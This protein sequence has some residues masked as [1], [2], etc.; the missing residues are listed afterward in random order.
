M[1]VKAPTP[2]AG[3]QTPA[4]EETSSPIDDQAIRQ[5]LQQALAENRFRLVYQ[6]I[7]PLHA[8][9]AE[10]YEV[11]IRMIDENGAEVPPASFMPV[12]EK[13]GLMSQIDRW[14]I[15]AAMMTL[16]KQHEA[17]KETSLLV[18]LSSES[19]AD[20]YLVAWIG[21]RLTG[22]H[23]PGDTLIFEIKESC[24][25][26]NPE[27]A[28]QLINGLKQLH[29]RTALGHF[30]S[31]PRS[32]DYLEQL[33]VDFIKLAG[34][35]VDNLS[36]DT[37]SQAMVKAVVQTAHD[38]GTLTVATFVQDASKMATLWQC[39]VDYIQGYFLQ[40]PDED[41]AYDFSEQDE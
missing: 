18:K 11:L 16:A 22:L 4:N 2:P 7:V 29:C 28:K 20:Q 14:V 35:F 1:Q 40:A 21:E 23:L 3:H 6:P 13:A 33:H 27:A 5:R 8:Q 17:G 31:D 30:G 37:K 9:P 36:G 41:M 25:M 38:L 12:A 39:N 24:V 15:G 26:R 34:T 19:V 32:L 10:R